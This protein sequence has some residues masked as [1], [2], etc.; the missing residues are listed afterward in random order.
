MDCC[1]VTPLH[2]RAIEIGDSFVCFSCIKDEPGVY[3]PS[4]ETIAV[5][6]DGFRTS[7]IEAYRNAKYVPYSHE[8][9]RI[10]ECVTQVFDRTTQEDFP[11]FDHDYWGIEYQL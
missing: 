3:L 4:Q 2:E 9:G 1:K 5:L 8:P 7:S 10:A 6:C 11:H